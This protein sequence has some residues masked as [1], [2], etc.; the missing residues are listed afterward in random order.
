MSIEIQVTDLHW[1][2]EEEADRDL[3]AH[4]NVT[5]TSSGDVVATGEDLAVSTGAVHL[6]RAIHEDHTPDAPLFEHLIPHCGH[7]MVADSATGSLINIGC[8]SGLNWWVQSV[9]GEVVLRFDDRI[10]QLGR[11]EWKTAV[12]SFSDSVRAFFERSAPKHPADDD[13]EWWPVFLEQWSH[14]RAGIE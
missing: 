1:I 13:Q 2:N 9:D 7:A 4:G 3:C 5:V 11:D 14:L 10:V 8:P 12:A 6:L